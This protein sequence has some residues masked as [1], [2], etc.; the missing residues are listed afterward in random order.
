MGTI[1][2]A[3]ISMN[4]FRASVDRG[5]SSLTAAENYMYGGRALLIEFNSEYVARRRESTD[6]RSWRDFS[7]VRPAVA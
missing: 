2:D 1:E 7:D 4:K 3:D 5:R 6:E